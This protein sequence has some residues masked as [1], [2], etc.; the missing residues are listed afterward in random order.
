MLL[1]F[2]WVFF[3]GCSDACGLRIVSVVVGYAFGVDV[4]VEGLGEVDHGFWFEESAVSMH[5]EA[6]GIQRARL[7]EISQEG[8]R[9]QRPHR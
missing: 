2:F 4:F 5:G 6:V 3:Y 7:G 8:E 9:D 1:V